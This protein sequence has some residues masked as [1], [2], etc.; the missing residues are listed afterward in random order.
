[1]KKYDAILVDVSNKYHAAYSTSAHLTMETPEGTLVT[2]G[3]YTFLKMMQRIRREYLADNGRFYFLFD[4][5]QSVEN[6]RKTIDPAYKANRYKKDPMFYRGLD[7]LNLILCSY[8]RGWLVTRRPGSEADDLVDSTI[9]YQHL[10]EK[11]TLLVSGDLDWARGISDNTDWLTS[12]YVD[13][14]AQDKV[15]DKVSYKEAY[16]YTP[17]R[18][19]VCLYKSFRGDA[20]DNIEIGIERIPEPVLLKIVEEYRDLPD[21]Y[22]RLNESTIP[23]QWKEAILNRKARLVINYSLVDYEQVSYQEYIDHTSWTRYEPE[24]LKRL[25]S[26]LGFNVQKLDPRMTQVGQKT[27][28][29]DD[30]FDF[31]DY[32]R[33]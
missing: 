9:K 16:G 4:N 27:K 24:I 2:G 7:Y 30:F 10:E 26:V 33:A 25:Y 21:L 20:S 13:K 23:P 22:K 32:G 14:R 19:S 29:G 3:V 6:R 1:M 18:E 28:E 31:Q 5:T 15:Y 17:S 12:V 11:S 8:E